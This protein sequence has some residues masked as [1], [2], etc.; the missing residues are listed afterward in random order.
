MSTVVTTLFWRDWK[1]RVV[2][3]CKIQGTNTA[4]YY[5]I[6]VDNDAIDMADRVS[7]AQW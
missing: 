1:E 7:V 3:I 5:V 4:G 2:I 6:V